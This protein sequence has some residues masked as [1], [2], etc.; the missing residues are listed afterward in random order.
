VPVF[1][2]LSDVEIQELN[3]RR[4]NLEE[5]TEYLVYL[6][7]LHSGDW[8]AIDLSKDDSQRTVKRRTSIAA[9]SQGKKIRWRRSPQ[10]NRLVFQVMPA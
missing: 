9:T 5:L 10:E 1:K 7:S 8:G 6:N 2:K 4:S 3:R